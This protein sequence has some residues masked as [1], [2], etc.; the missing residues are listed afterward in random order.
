MCDPLTFMLLGPR[1]SER[2]HLD[3][4]LVECGS[5]SFLEIGTIER[6]ITGCVPRQR[7]TSSK[8]VTC[9][10]IGGWSYTRMNVDVSNTAVSGR[11]DQ[12][13]KNQ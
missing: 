10:L 9:S 12:R 4:A 7:D 1:A 13:V 5:F 2:K 8:G 11:V 3:A 6:K